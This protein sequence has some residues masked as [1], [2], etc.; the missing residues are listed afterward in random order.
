MDSKRN[1]S[2]PAV[3]PVCWMGLAGAECTHTGHPWKNHGQAAAPAV[4][5]ESQDGLDRE[6]P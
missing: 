6:G 5:V 4:I 3:F 1:F 2:I